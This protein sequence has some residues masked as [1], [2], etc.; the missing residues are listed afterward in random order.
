MINRD[1]I[2]KVVLE[3]RKSKIQS[4]AEVC[5]KLLVPLIEEL[6]FATELRAQEFPVY[7]WHGRNKASTT[8]ADFLLFS[9]DQF[10]LYRDYSEKN[11][12]W[13]QN[14]SLLVCEA[15]KPG[16]MDEDS[17]QAEFYALWTRCPAYIMCDGES[18]RAFYHNPLKADKK[19]IDCSIDCL[20]ENPDLDFFSYENVVKAKEYIVDL[21]PEKCDYQVLKPEDINLPNDVVK[22]MRQSL[23]LPPHL[24]DYDVMLHFLSLTDA[25]LERG[26]RYGIPEYMLEIPRAQY[27][28]SLYVDRDVFPLFSGT[29]THYFRDEID[30]YDFENDYVELH[31]KCI[32]NKIVGYYPDYHVQ[33]Q[34]SEERERILNQVKRVFCAQTLILRI[35]GIPDKEIHT[36]DFSHGP[37]S[38]LALETIRINY[39]I[40]EMRKIQVIEKTFGIEMDLHPLN[41]YEEGVILYQA[42]DSLYRSIIRDQNCVIFFPSNPEVSEDIVIEE[43]IPFEYGDIHLPVLNI[44][45]FL[46]Y[47]SES[48]ILPTTVKKEIWRT[49][50]IEVPACCVYNLEKNDNSESE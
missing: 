1:T 9:D 7:S 48:F 15:K 42:V 26:V 38:P 35:E 5:S 18:I 3:Y 44:H 31:L 28:A 8:H 49:N 27:E 37:D 29:V 50:T 20:Y 6:G 19:I 33:C 47:P 17:G 34:S 25:Y 40:D 46:F 36:S 21:S 11:R 45:G 13:V 16:K 39:W 30:I 12:K 32:E 22:G 41:D 23:N 2:R 43:M 24:S 4:E 10:A 14:H